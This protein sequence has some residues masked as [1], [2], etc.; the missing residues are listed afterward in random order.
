MKFVIL[1]FL[2]WGSINLCGARDSSMIAQEML[3]SK[4]ECGGLLLY[5]F[6]WSI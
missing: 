4:L 3:G 5:A 2:S 6:F 1:H